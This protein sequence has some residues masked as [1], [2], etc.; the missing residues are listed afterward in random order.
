VKVG[1]DR[2]SKNTMS[3]FQIFPKKLMV[4]AIE[5]GKYAARLF[6]NMEQYGNLHYNKICPVELRFDTEI[7]GRWTMVV[8]ETDI[9]L[10]EF[11]K[12]IAAMNFYLFSI[13]KY[14]PR[15]PLPETPLYPEEF[16]FQPVFFDTLEGKITKMP[17]KEKPSKQWR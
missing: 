16:Y 8:I 14:Q 5:G 9:Q 7:G 10:K 1:V 11:D 6:F 15:G 12:F 17:E 2:T 3:Y 4:D 13:L